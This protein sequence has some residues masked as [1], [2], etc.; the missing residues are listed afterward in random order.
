MDEE[1]AFSD[2]MGCYC[3]APEFNCILEYMGFVQKNGKEPDIELAAQLFLLLTNEQ[4]MVKCQSL[5]NF[6]CYL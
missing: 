4:S 5:F 2:L 1:F 3:D 6:L